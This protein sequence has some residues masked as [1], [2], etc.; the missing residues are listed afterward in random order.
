MNWTSSVGSYF[1]RRLT[2]FSDVGEDAFWRRR[3]RRQRTRAR[4]RRAKPTTPPTTPPAIA[5]ALDFL[6]A[7]FPSDPAAPV[8][9]AEF[10]DVVLSSDLAAASLVE[11]AQK[12]FLWCRKKDSRVVRVCGDVTDSTDRVIASG[13]NNKLICLRGICWKH[14][15]RL[16]G[17]VLRL[18][19]VRSRNH[20]RRPP[21][22]FRV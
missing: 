16:T 10:V 4:P 6:E 22:R 11:S 14:E 19:R 1:P 13:S 15:E 18:S 20:L 5:P 17:S 2:G 9:D 3:R 21:P 8:E 7:G 12:V